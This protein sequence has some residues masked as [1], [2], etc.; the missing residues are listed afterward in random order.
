MKRWQRWTFNALA[1]VVSAT[2]FAY[3]WMKYFVEAADAFAVVNHPWQVPALSLHVIASPGFIFVFGIVLDAHVMKK[4]G[5]SALP[6][7]R[8]GYLS[9]GTLALM[10]LSGYL[11]QVTSDAAW[12][13]AL[14]IAHVAAGAVF[15]LTYGAHLV[16]S[17]RLGRRQNSAVREVA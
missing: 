16:V 6:N 1:F 5:A 8:S 11:L 2:G 17:A 15:S 12:L 14:V 7:R 13:R 9:L 4:L 10:V 3:L